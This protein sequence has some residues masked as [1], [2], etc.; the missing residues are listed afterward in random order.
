MRDV[1]FMGFLSLCLAFAVRYPFTALLTWAWFTLA[2]PQMAAYYAQSLPLNLLIAAVTFVALFMHSEYKRFRFDTITVLML[3]F[4]F[5]LIVSQNQSLDPEYSAE[6]FDRFLKIMIFI[7]LCAQL[8]TDRLRFH[9]LLWVVIIIMGF[10]GAKGGAYT[11]LTLGRNNYFGLENT[12]LFDN[13]HMGVALATVLPLFLYIHGQVAS[14]WV[15]H[16]IKAVFL[17]S[18]IAILG[19]FSRGALVALIVFAGFMWLRSSKRLLY[20]GLVV[21]MMIPAALLLPDRWFDRMETIGTATQDDSF[22]G[23]VDAWVI[24][25]KLAREHPLTGVGMRN[26]YQEPIARQVDMKRTPRAAHSIYFEILGGMG[27]VGLFIYL[28]I[29]G[30]AFLKAAS[31]YTRYRYAKFGHWRSSFGYHAQISLVVFG[32]GGA[33]ISMEMW[34]GYLIIIALIASLKRIEPETVRSVDNRV[35]LR[36]REKVEKAV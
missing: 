32:V 2:T 14:K 24:N 29:L 11:I 10:Y 12:I 30:V 17:L 15:R 3:L 13:N 33:S 23:R 27:F 19:T 20:L 1:I 5:W 26:S 8:V 7:L 4:A 28:G 34:E 9:A 21:A 35:T 22:M 6:P 25:Y 18:I 31:A 36:I 16:G